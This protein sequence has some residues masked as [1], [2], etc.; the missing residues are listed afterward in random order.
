[1]TLRILRT[2]LGKATAL[3]TAAACVLTACEVIPPPPQPP[4]AI[5]TIGAITLTV[6]TTPATIN[7]SGYFYD[8]D[9]QTLTYSAR[10]SVRAVATASASGSTVTLTAIAEGTASITVTATDEDNLTASQT[11]SVTVNPAPISEPEPQAPVAIGTIGAVTLTV[12]ATPATVNVSGYFYDPDDQTLTYSARSSVR[13]V[14]TASASGSTVTLT[15]IAEGTASIT[16][17]ATDEDNL[18]AS[19]TFSVTVNPVPI[20]GLTLP[21]TIVLNPD[22]SALTNELYTLPLVTSSAEV[23]VISTNT[24]T[25]HVAP[26]LVRLD[27]GRRA[28]QIS[29]PRPAASQSARATREPEWLREIQLPPRRVGQAQATQVQTPVAEGDSFTF[30]EH[31]NNDIIVPVPATVRRVIRAGTT[32]LAVWVADRE[33]QVSCVERCLTQEMVDAFASRFLRPG[34]SNDIYDWVTTIFGA[35]WGPH[36]YSNLIPPEAAGE[37]HILLLDIEGDDADHGIAGYFFSLH[38][39]LYDPVYPT[40]RTSAE[41]LIFFIDSPILS[42]PEGPTWEVTDPHPSVMLGTLGAR[43]SAHDSLLPEADREWSSVFG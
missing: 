17:T 18:T 7:V 24:T 14:A 29:Q 40:T 13:A 39:V 30:I 2:V 34:V 22:G 33:W 43:V 10:S 42:I 20:S 9:D 6:G 32:T 25:R 8:P 5:G 11:F 27:S 4:T 15:A 31:R 38:N 16:V 37:I 26:H 21:F 12:G 41:R 1:M 19:Q 23:F 28:E 3:G 36:P 35:P